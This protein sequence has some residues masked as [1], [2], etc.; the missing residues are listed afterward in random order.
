MRNSRTAPISMVPATNRSDAFLCKPAT[1]AHSLGLSGT[2]GLQLFRCPTEAPLALL[3]RCNRGP[4][5]SRV[6]IRPKQIGEIE[7]GVYEL[8]KQEVGDAL[9]PAGTNEQIRLR[10]VCH[11]EVR[12]QR[13]GSEP[14]RRLGMRAEKA[15]GGLR[16]VPPTAVI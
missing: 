4:E 3:V 10:S 11:R 13:L 8:P 9:L 2:F 15:I 7:L 14:T 6:E 12:L 16:D 1:F 5:R